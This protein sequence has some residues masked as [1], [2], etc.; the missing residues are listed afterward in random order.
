MLYSHLEIKL[1]RVLQLNHR[2]LF[3]SPNPSKVDSQIRVLPFLS[4]VNLWL[5]L[6]SCPVT[7]GQKTGKR[8]KRPTN[9]N[10]IQT[11]QTRPSLALGK[12]VLLI[13]L[14]MSNLQPKKRNHRSPINYRKR[15][16][17]CC[18]SKMGAIY[19]SYAET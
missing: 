4:S 8:N 3:L 17:I 16:C 7:K 1:P 9:P 12:A 18:I 5:E 15:L 14:V 19:R 13:T 6:M 11:K 10:L 2:E